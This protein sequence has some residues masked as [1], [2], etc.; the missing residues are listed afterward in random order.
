MKLL[1]ENCKLNGLDT[2]SSCKKLLWGEELTPD[3]QGSYNV[4]IGADIIYEKEY[5]APLFAT[6]SHFL[7]RS[8]SRNIFYL[9]YT[10]RNVSIDYVLACASNVGFTWIAPITDEGIYAFT[11]FREG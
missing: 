10:K 5:V 11:L 1:E 4:V 2:D 6:A 7:G 8:S 9:A 3:T